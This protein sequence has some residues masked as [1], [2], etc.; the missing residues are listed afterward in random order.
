MVSIMLYILIF[1][2]VIEVTTR[3][4]KDCGNELD[5]FLWGGPC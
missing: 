4:S 2:L 3:V 5:R 1:F